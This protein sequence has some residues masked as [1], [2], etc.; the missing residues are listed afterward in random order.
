MAHE[1]ATRAVHH[2]KSDLS[3]AEQN[4]LRQVIQSLLVHNW[5]PGEE[6]ARVFK[7]LVR[8]TY[9]IFQKGPREQPLKLD[10]LQTLLL[11][12]GVKGVPTEFRQIDAIAG[13]LIS[14]GYI[15]AKA[16]IEALPIGLKRKR[17]P[18]IQQA[19]G[20]TSGTVGIAK[21]IVASVSSLIRERTGR[22]LK[23]M[24]ITPATR[25]M[26]VLMVVSI[27]PTRGGSDTELLYPV[28]KRIK[29]TLKVQLALEPVIPLLRATG[30]G[31]ITEEEYLRIRQCATGK[32]EHDLTL[33]LIKR[34]K[35]KLAAH[36]TDH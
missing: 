24:E 11:L 16:F 23:E 28:H 1:I 27:L 32:E 26:I 5:R 6:G 36:A 22:S 15:T 17:K 35:Q 3:V 34:A 7:R 29:Y 20:R 21:D 8:T 2:I 18:F 10:L 9:K 14:V 12:P 31:L 19:L 33:A 13:V 4:T 25:A 30:L